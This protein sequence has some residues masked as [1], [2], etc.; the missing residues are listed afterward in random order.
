MTKRYF[1]YAYDELYG[2]Q[3]GIYDFTFFYGTFKDACSLGC[4]KSCEVIRS[5][6]FIEE[7]IYE[8]CETDEEYDDALEN[9]IAYEVYE[10]N[11]DAPSDDELYELNYSPLLYIEEFCK[12]E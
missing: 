7:N 9:D 1:I 3:H 5:Y 11:D 10:V 4:E 12:N 8:G 6:S 2:G